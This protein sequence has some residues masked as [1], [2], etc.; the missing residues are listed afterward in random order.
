MSQTQKFK[1]GS[2]SLDSL[3]DSEWERLALLELITEYERVLRQQK[4]RL[5]PAVIE[6][7]DSTSFW[8][9]WI[10]ET[11]TIRL[12]RRLL[13]E[14][15]WF[16]T[17]SI[18]KHEMAHQ[19]VDERPELLGENQKTLRRN[20]LGRLRNQ[21][22][23]EPPHETPHGRLFQSACAKLGV[24]SEFS[25]ASIDL[26]SSSLDWRTEQHDPVSEKMLGKV[27]K[28][29]ALA[30]SADE[31]EA[32]LAMDRVREIYSRYNLSPT[33]DLAY[34]HLVISTKSKRM[35]THVKKIAGILAGHF[36]VQV[37]LGQIYSPLT[38]THH[39]MLEIIGRREN[40]LMAEYVY[41]FLN[42]QSERLLMDYITQFAAINGKLTRVGRKSYRLGILQGFEQKLADHDLQQETPRHER[43]GQPTTPLSPVPAIDNQ[44]E[45]A[46][47]SLAL[48]S[49]RSDRSLQG[50]LSQVYPRLYT[51]RS[52]SQRIDRA[53]YAA[54]RSAGK[55]I[56]LHKAVSSASPNRGYLSAARKN[57]S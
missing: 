3:T 12:A 36:F 14:Q 28:L 24:P 4:V 51:S 22:S 49:F 1:P 37:V 21:T 40:V 2:P 13:L 7:C 50:Y 33:E 57:E 41:H 44:S 19:L 38:G 9:Q 29:L 6:F 46:I 15:S 53:A 16:Q 42:D 5:R 25:K 26:Q 43:P 39:R 8:G 48:S 34:V 23:N 17:I 31:H 45:R 11:R 55:Q 32:L 47:V 10:R 27:K 20:A 54:G 18:L 56:T 35:E 52:G 30:N